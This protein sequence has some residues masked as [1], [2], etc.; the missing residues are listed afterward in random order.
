MLR[1]YFKCDIVKVGI[2][3]AAKFKRINACLCNLYRT[4]YAFRNRAVAKNC[5]VCRYDC[6]IAELIGICVQRLTAKTSQADFKRA[7]TAP[8]G[9]LGFGLSAK[10]VEKTVEVELDQKKVQMKY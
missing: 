7:L 10:E 3:T 2:R 5:A 1:Y 6:H 8:E 9:N 4:D